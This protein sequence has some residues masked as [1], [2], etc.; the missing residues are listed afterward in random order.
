[1]KKSKRNI[2]WLTGGIITF[3][4]LG[5]LIAYLLVT[6]NKEAI[7]DMAIAEINHR[8]EGTV[9]LGSISPAFFTT[10]PHLSVCL[11]DLLIRDSL[12][13][14]HHHDLLQ[15]KKI[16]ISFGWLSLFRG[17]PEVCKVV[18]QNGSIHSYTDACG[19][20][21]IIQTE[22]IH[23]TKSHHPLPEFS[24][25]HTRL[26]LENEMMNSLHD[27]DADLLHCQ[28]VRTDSALLLHLTVKAL[29]H[30]VGFNLEKGSYL[31]EKK[32]EGNFH[33]TYIPEDRIELK[34]VS[35]DIARQPFT[36]K[37]NIFL[38][39]DTMSY[40]LLFKTNQI[41]YQEAISL[42]TQSIQQ[43]VNFIDIL[44]PF[45][46]EATVA[47]QM[48]R[49]VIPRI[50]T[51]F[52]VKES[53]M[54]TSLGRLEKCTYS[55]SFI[56]QVDPLSKPG[57][58]NSKFTFNEVS[59]DWNNIPLTSAKIEITNLLN[60]YLVCDIASVFTL[61]EL[62]T[63]FGSSTMKFLSG[64]G[65]LDVTYQGS[66][67]G[68]DTI[69]PVLNGTF[70][71]QDAEVHYLPRDLLFKKCSGEIEFKDQALVLK[72]LMASI[73]HSEFT[74]TG[75]IQNLLAMINLNPEQLTIDLAISTP[76]LD[77]GDFT[78]YVRTSSAT[79]PKV[80]AQ[81]N[82]IVQ[83]AENTDRMFRNGTARLNVNAGE[84]RYKKFN[85]NQVKASIL[86]ETNKITLQ[87]VSLQHAK[88]KA[89]LKG[90]M[91][92]GART[93]NLKL[94]SKINA[95]DIPLLFKA[96]DN[97]GQDAVTAA[98]TK[99][100]LTAEII[101]A[102]E[103][104]DRA[105]VKESTMKGTIDFSVM[106]GE[107]NQFEPVMKMTEVA[108]KKRDFSQI[109]FA[110]LRNQ[111]VIDGSAFQIQKMEIRSNVVVLFVEGIYD[112]KKGTDMSIQVPLS[113]LSKAENEI[114]ENKGKAG[115]NIRLRAK[116][117]LDGKLNV[118]WDPLNNAS[119]QRKAA[120]KDDANPASGNDTP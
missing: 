89:T 72:N 19:Y 28:I 3:F 52:T 12:W 46:V 5:W 43:H 56:N 65:K 58:A 115:F 24:L 103:I 41:E 113:N 116:T 101:V 49:K 9:T 55:G 88:G 40:D 27:I 13:E 47:G 69:M 74:M 2:L 10:F 53:P 96:F 60:P 77:L 44:H 97:F 83:V 6:R 42:L 110:E 114:M 31:R 21:N 61:T 84:V 22:H 94:E 16:Y 4:F 23:S 100:L 75:N 93:N 48:A 109:K 117:G 91:I 106:H 20:S 66:M 30:G 104:T 86:L 38:E 95:M 62:D 25:R 32:L 14:Q 99:G 39:A 26:I 73:G 34:D 78:S 63:L 45:D 15:A 98:N 68:T 111:L 11:S 119:K 102:C 118:S 36:I 81:K 37:G 87:N 33:L 67:S 57:D 70:T 17:K 1:L 18:I 7:H 64:T 51:H 79:T 120:I 50:T 85:A 59:A 54:E 92:N 108:F 80:S 107:L 35:L 90:T 82:K 76:A 29:V 105:T 71:L 8:I 112:T